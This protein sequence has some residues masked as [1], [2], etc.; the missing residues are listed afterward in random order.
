[1]KEGMDEMTT[2]P[3]IGLYVKLGVYNDCI[4]DCE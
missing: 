4:G 3:G 2:M 1:M